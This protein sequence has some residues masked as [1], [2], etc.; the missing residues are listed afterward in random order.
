MTIIET[1]MTTTLFE[2]WKG[3]DRLKIV[4]TRA[5]TGHKCVDER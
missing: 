1:S 5:P 4:E 2:D 3:F